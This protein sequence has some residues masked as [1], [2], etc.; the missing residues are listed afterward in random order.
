M[1]WFG[2]FA[3]LSPS[4]YPFL[5]PFLSPNQFKLRSFSLNF[6]NRNAQATCYTGGER[7]AVSASPQKKNKN[8]ETKKNTKPC[9]LHLP[10]HWQRSGNCWRAGPRRGAAAAAERWRRRGLRGVGGSA[11]AA[12]LP[13]GPGARRSSPRSA[14]LSPPLPPPPPPAAADTPAGREREENERG[15]RGCLGKGGCGVWTKPLRSTPTRPSLSLSPPGVGRWG[16]RCQPAAAGLGI[17]LAAS[18]LQLG[19]GRIYMI[20][21]HR[22]LFN[23]QLI[24]R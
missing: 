7:L 16:R 8:T 14:P 15:S 3:F 22:F 12:A 21:P 20:A 1:V 18:P 2:Y 13:G 23:G 11:A 9:P 19:V 5:S 10:P 24:F 17:R 6:H 4:P